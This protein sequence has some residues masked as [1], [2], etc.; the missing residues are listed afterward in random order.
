M[1]GRVK[2]ELMFAD[3]ADQQRGGGV[4]DVFQRG[5]RTRHIQT[6]YHNTNTG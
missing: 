3:N 1:F 6:I 2:F 5:D 4:A